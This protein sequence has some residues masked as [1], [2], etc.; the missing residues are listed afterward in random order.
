MPA[1][2]I[3]EKPSAGPYGQ[4][5][6]GSVEHEFVGPLV[7]W[8]MVAGKGTFTQLGG[9][10]RCARCQRVYGVGPNGSFAMRTV[11]SVDEVAARRAEV[12]VLRPPALPMPLPRPRV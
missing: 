8:R 4:C 5:Q 3:T 7:G 6:C 10:V 11:P 9:I 12:E 2:R 1:K